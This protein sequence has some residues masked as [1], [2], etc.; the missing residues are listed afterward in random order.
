MVKEKN[1]EPDE[2]MIANAVEVEPEST[3]DA[4][5]Q[6]RILKDHKTAVENSLGDVNDKI[7]YL[8][9]F[10]FK[11][12]TIPSDGT[13]SETISVPGA[14][15]VYKEQLIGAQVGDWEAWRKYLNRHGFGAV[16]RQQ[17][18][19]APLQDLFEMIMS[20]ELP[21]PKSATFTP[22]E[23]LKCHVGA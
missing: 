3:V 12:L 1:Y 22:Y 16:A 14:G 15:S 20:G 13:K 10:L 4:M 17:N 18:N 8:E 7:K 9:G 11:Q 23:K 19:I 21:T 5:S 6:W 2:E